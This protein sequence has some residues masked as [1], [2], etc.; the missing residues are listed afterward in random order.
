MTSTDELQ[1]LEKIA[2]VI[3]P[4]IPGKQLAPRLLLDPRTN[5]YFDNESGGFTADA[6]ALTIRTQQALNWLEEWCEKHEGKHGM[7]VSVQYVSPNGREDEGETYE[8]YAVL[9]TD[10]GDVCVEGSAPSLPA[11][12][13]RTIE[14]LTKEKT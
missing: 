4:R 10:A 5:V 3:D 7:V 2:G 12:L 9:V 13:A 11:A 8:P 1:E 14:A 6:T